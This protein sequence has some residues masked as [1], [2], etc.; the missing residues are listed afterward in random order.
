MYN[1]KAEI[2]TGFKFDKTESTIVLPPQHIRIGNKDYILIAEENGKLNILSRVG[3]ERIKLNKT[4]DFS[5]IP[6]KKEGSDFVVITS[7]NV[8]KSISQNGEISSQTLQVSNDYTFEIEGTTK[9]TLDDNLLR[10]NGLLVELPLGV[11]AKPQIFR[12]NKKTYIAITELK[13]NKVYLYLKDGTLLPNFP[14]YGT[15]QIDLADANKNQKINVLV[16]GEPKEIIL[17]QTD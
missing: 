9:V 2:V 3:K 11:Y 5:D 1:S 16:K 15:T 13:E 8:K 12:V 14:I 6:I 10:I 7:D 17:Y 4:F